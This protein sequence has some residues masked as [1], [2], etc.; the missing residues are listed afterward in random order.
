MGAPI[1][2]AAKR[3]K[4]ANKEK[5]DQNTIN[6]L[7]EIAVLTQLG[8]HDHVI[9]YLGVNNLNNEMYMVFEYAEKGI[10]IKF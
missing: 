4:N 3:L 5:D 1:K 2:V 9:E 10:L 8:K 6:L 7:A